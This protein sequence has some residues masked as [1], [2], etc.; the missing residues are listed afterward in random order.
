MYSVSVEYSQSD[1]EKRTASPLWHRALE[2][3]REELNQTDD[4]QSVTEIASL[5]DLLNYTKTI[6]KS[7]PRDRNAFG[8]LQRLGPA[9]KFVDDFSAVIAVCFG[10]DAKL[11]A[12]VWGSIRLMLTLASSAGD[13]L[14]DVLDMFEELS[15]TL[16]MLRTYETSLEMNRALGAALV[17]VYTEVICFYARCIHFFRSHPHALLRRGAWEDFRDD[18]AHTLKRIRR[19]AT[20]VESEADFARM[21]CDRGKYDE[22]LGL[23]EKLKETKL[24]EDGPKL[25]QN[26]PSTLNPRFWGREDALN[27][28]QEA[29]S[30]EQKSR[31]FKTFALYGMGGVGKTQIA[32]QYANRHRESYKAILWVTLIT[33]SIWD[34]VFARLRSCSGYPKL[35]SKCKTRKGAC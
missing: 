22:V 3:Y 26:I 28:L 27:A 35:S 31:Q 4:Y 24:K 18:F 7:L 29:L 32:L 23:M 2:R 14:K 20:T 6:E 15:L 33:S 12:F 19:L 34:R 10:A 13:T 5:D 1:R 30:P 11:T 17:D 16:P 8:S 9:L 25:Y 21:K